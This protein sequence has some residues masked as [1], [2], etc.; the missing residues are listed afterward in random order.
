MGKQSVNKTIHT[1]Q[2]ALLP[3]KLCLDIKF[4]KLENYIFS[5]C[6]FLIRQCTNVNRKGQQKRPLKFKTNL[7]SIPFPYFHLRRKW[8]SFNTDSCS[9]SSSNWESIT[10]KD[11]TTE[12]SLCTYC[13]PKS[14]WA[15]NM[16]PESSAMG[17][18]QPKCLWWSKHIDRIASNRS[19]PQNWA[20]EISCNKEQKKQ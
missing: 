2:W 13:N 18:I 17:S 4:N 5:F 19:R 3:K 20:S 8:R 7:F 6:L 10:N 1:K 14:F 9:C 15:N 11:S 16:R 12:D